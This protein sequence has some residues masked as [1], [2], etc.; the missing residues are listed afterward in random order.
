LLLHL[1]ESRGFRA[2]LCFDTLQDF[3]ARFAAPGMTAIVKYWEKNLNI[4]Y[5]LFKMSPIGLV[6][7]S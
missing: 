2:P 5:S 1:C 6:Y 4:R 3:R 7:S